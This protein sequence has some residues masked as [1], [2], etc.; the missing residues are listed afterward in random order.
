[1]FRLREKPPAPIPF[2]TPHPE[3]PLVTKVRTAIEQG[4]NVRR[5]VPSLLTWILQGPR[6][7][8]KQFLRAYDQHLRGIGRSAVDA[9]KEI[10]A[11]WLRER[12]SLSKR[13]YAQEE[14]IHVV[15]KELEEARREFMA[16][17]K[18]RHGGQPPLPSKR[19]GD[20]SE[21]S[22]EHGAT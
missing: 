4:V 15:K 16:M 3:R 19:N 17:E 9:L 14:E 7:A 11:E 13:M 10:D 18:E 1:L 21:R 20:T 8:M 2:T 12:A 22:Q 6:R 5:T